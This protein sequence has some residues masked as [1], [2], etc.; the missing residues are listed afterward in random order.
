MSEEETTRIKKR[1]YTSLATYIRKVLKQVHPESGIRSETIEEVQRLVEILAHK[2]MLASNEL[3]QLTESKS[4]NSR[5]IQTAVK[6]VLSGYLA[7]ESVSQGTK[8]VTIYNSNISADKEES[9]RKAP[10][11]M[12]KKAE[13]QFSPT[14]IEKLFIRP[15][16][17]VGILRK[18][19]SVYLTAVLEYITAEILEIGGNVAKEYKVVQITPRHLL[20]AIKGDEELNELFKDTT[21]PGGVVPEIHESLLPSK[22]SK[23]ST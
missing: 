22:R 3:L 8:A 19:A 21:L 9:G 18:T 1:D 16:M 17:S 5:A 6:L 15:Q 14:R 23:Q 13:L 7:R 2:I 12:A 11:S 20:L 10:V 4:L